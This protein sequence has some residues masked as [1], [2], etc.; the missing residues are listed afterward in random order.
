MITF[1]AQSNLQAPGG[2]PRGY[3]TVDPLLGTTSAATTAT[4]SG[5]TTGTI[6]VATSN[7]SVSVDGTYTGTVT[8]SD[9]G[10]G[11][12][13]APT[14]VSWIS[15]SALK[16]FTYTPAQTGTIPISIT[17]APSLTI[18]GSPINLVVGSG[19]GTVTIFVDPRQGTILN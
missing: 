17:A 7:Y 4:L 15:S 16:T 13:F 6:D 14:S 5:P 18:S 9:S 12:L 2:F 19:P 8:P 1:P 11:G 3:W 10:A